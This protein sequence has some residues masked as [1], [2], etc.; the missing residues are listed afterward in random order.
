MTVTAELGS[1]HSFSTCRVQLLTH[2]NTTGV[3][4]TETQVFGIFNDPKRT[5][6]EV[7]GI[8]NHSKDQTSSGHTVTLI[9]TVHRIARPHCLIRL[10]QSRKKQTYQTRQY[11]YVDRKKKKP[12]NMKTSPILPSVMLRFPSL[13]LK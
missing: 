10:S 2:W 8:F 5:K 6:R 3:S 12:Q 11:I 13:I 7:F 4:T 1:G 9:D